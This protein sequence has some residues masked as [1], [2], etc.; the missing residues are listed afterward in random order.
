MKPLLAVDIGN[1]SVHMALYKNSWKPFLRIRTDAFKNGIPKELASKINRSP[2]I[3]VIIGSVVPGTTQ[4][5]KTYFKTAV[6]GKVLVA[7]VDTKIPIAN[8]YKNPKQVGMDRLL[9]ALAG[10]SLYKKPLIIIDFGTAITFDVVSKKGEYLGGVIAPGIEIS[11]DALFERT[12]LLPQ[13]KLKHPANRIG[14]DTVESIR[15]GCS[16]GIAG[17]CERLIQEITQQLGGRPT[18]I[19]TG[20]YAL[21][22]K[23]YC[24]SIEAIY[25]NLTMDGLRLTFQS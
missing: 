10:Y 12:A 3:D 7:G 19:A 11:L 22:M 23:R 24:P 21:F 18:V 17:L 4:K 1:T 6:T 8:R 15:I 16:Y 2:D 14:R 5:L 9:N 20:G 25:P 13:T